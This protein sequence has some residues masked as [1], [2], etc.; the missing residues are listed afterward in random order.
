M[1]TIFVL[2]SEN[3]DRIFYA[4]CMATTAAALDKKV[5]IF[6]SGKAIRYITKK[7]SFKD[8]E[9]KES[10][11]K[12]QHQSNSN[13]ILFKELISSSIDLKINFSYCSM[14]ND[15]VTE[16]I[17]FF[18]GIKIRAENLTLIFNEKDNQQNRIIF[19]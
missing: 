9:V 7:I 11:L 2:N 15:L 6:F 19:I 10:L 3:F 18:D 17:Q 13:F 8:E 5:L 12:K 14:I 4:F 16:P 1:K